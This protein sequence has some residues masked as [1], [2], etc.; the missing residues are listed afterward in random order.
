MKIGKVY[1]LFSKSWQSKDIRL[2]TVT[3]ENKL[4]VQGVQS[5]EVQAIGAREL[6]KGNKTKFHGKSK[7]PTTRTNIWNRNRF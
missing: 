6:R 7:R 4:R 3:V 5:N 2:V 1:E